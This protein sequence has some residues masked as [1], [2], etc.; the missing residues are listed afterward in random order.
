MHKLRK[1]G[2]LMALSS[3]NE[4]QD[5]TDTHTHTHT[6]THTYTGNM[7]VLSLFLRGPTPNSQ[8]EVCC[9]VTCVV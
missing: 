6:H 2:K 3:S 4:S 7:H 8:A 5:Q 9:S 1:I